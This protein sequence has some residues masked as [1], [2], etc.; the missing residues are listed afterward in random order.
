MHGFY[1]V[2]NLEGRFSPG[3]PEPGKLW[4]HVV[5]ER[6]SEAWRRRKRPGLRARHRLGSWSDRKPG[7]LGGPRQAF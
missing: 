3:W 1:S 2:P 4:P 7:T 5:K 6:L